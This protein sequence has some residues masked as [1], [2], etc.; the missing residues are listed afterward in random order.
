MGASMYE[1][2]VQEG[3]ETLFGFEFLADNAT[4]T[5]SVIQGWDFGAPQVPFVNVP[6]TKSDTHEDTRRAVT[7]QQQSHEFFVTGTISNKCKGPCKKTN[8]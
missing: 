5:K 2:N 6:P 7:A 1:S 8:H 4:T 3:N